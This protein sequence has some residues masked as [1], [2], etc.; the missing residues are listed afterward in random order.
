MDSQ[1]TDES[2]PASSKSPASG[3]SP[4]SPF[5]S[6]FTKKWAEKLRTKAKRGG[7]VKATGGQNNRKTYSDIFKA[8]VLDDMAKLKRIRP[9]IHDL[10]FHVSEKWKIPDG[11]VGGWWRMREKIH[12]SAGVIPMVLPQLRTRIQKSIFKKNRFR[13]HG[14][15]IPPSDFK[16]VRILYTKSIVDSSTTIFKKLRG[17]QPLRFLKMTD[18]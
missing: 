5:G 11:L 1:G 3:K 7:G 12:K 9:V 14:F 2:T 10:Y 6:P 18:Y 8:E 16:C 15:F 17:A 4:K 13:N